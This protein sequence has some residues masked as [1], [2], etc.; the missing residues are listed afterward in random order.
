MLQ[1]LLIRPQLFPR[2]GPSQQ[3]D[4][5][6]SARKV[7]S[8]GIGRGCSNESPV[9]QVSF[10]AGTRF[11][12]SRLWIC[13]T[14]WH[15]QYVLWLYTST[16][17]WKRIKS[18]D[19]ILILLYHQ[20]KHPNSTAHREDFDVLCAVLLLRS[21]FEGTGFTLSFDYDSL[22]RVMSLSVDIGR[23]I[24]CCLRLTETYFDIIHRDGIKTELGRHH[25]D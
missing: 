17:T 8:I 7:L 6:K 25:R 24:C 13:F 3:R 23:P 19:G 12:V 10:A 9:G 15:L 16:E 18:A 2:S 4:P 14:C 20:R 21:C 1:F 11:I 5:K 22:K